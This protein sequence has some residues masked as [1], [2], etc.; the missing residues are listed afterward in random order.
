VKNAEEKEEEKKKKDD[1]EM[2][3]SLDKKARAEGFKSFEELKN[4]AAQRGK[5]LDIPLGSRREQAKAGAERYG[6]TVEA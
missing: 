3:N 5:P 4:A 2:K 6:K 1:E